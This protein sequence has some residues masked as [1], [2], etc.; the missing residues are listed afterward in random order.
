MMTSTS[1]EILGTTV[2]SPERTS[3]NNLLAILFFLMG[4]P[5]IYGI[6]QRGSKRRKLV[7]A[8]SNR[9]SLLVQLIS[10]LSINKEVRTSLD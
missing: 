10:F 9:L 8:D 5:H 6:I 3:K 1:Q 4:A 2:S 7:K